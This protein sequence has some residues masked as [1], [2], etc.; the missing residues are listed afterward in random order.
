VVTEAPVLN[1]TGGVIGKQFVGAL[2]Y[3]KDLSRPGGGVFV[4]LG[5]ARKVNF[6]GVTEG[7]IIN[8]S[9]EEIEAAP[10]S[11]SMVNFTPL[12]KEGD[13]GASNVNP[14]MDTPSKPGNVQVMNVLDVPQ[15]H[16]TLEQFALADNGFLEGIPGG[17]FDWGQWD[18]FFSRFSGENA[19]GLAGFQQRQQQQK[20]S[21]S[22]AA[23]PLPNLEQS[24]DNQN[25]P[26][27]QY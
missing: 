21:G 1:P 4:A 17:M 15:A 26:D 18:T 2:A 9:D 22:A 24:Q 27:L 16:N 25:G 8:G 14:A 23:N 3:K 7:T 11:T 10:R 5:D 13:E 19:A 20:N 6:E 12:R